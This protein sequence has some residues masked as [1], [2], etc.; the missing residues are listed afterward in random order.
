MIA[1][2]HMRGLWEALDVAAVS[3]HSVCLTSVSR[4]FHHHV[5]T[6]L[7]I[8]RRSMC[9]GACHAGTASWCDLRDP[10]W[11]DPGFRHHDFFAWH[12]PATLLSFGFVLLFWGWP[13]QDWA[14]KLPCHYVSLP[15]LDIPF[16]LVMFCFVLGFGVFCF[17]SVCVLFGLFCVWLVAG[18]LFILE[19]YHQYMHNEPGS[20]LQHRLHLQ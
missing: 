10:G 14:H 7:G 18:F 19:W 13:A 15:S 11:G 20:L 12:L 9:I 2:E 16:Q 8:S 5:F 17:G 3:S 6:L 1:K 4:T